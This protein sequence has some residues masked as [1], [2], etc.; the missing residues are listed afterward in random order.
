MRAFFTFEAA[1]VIVLVQLR[2]RK[3]SFEWRPI[4]PFGSGAKSMPLQAQPSNRGLPQRA[5]C[6]L[7]AVGRS[8]PTGA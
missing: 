4:E 6:H 2:V 7:E 1:G 5:I 8:Q 3:T